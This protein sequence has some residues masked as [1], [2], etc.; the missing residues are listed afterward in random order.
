MISLYEDR[1]HSLLTCNVKYL[2]RE[3]ISCTTL[4]HDVF[5]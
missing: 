3:V 4:A 5:A 2:F 1:P